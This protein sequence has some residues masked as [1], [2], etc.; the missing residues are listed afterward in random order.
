[1]ATEEDG[2]KKGCAKAQLGENCTLQAAAD[3]RTGNV[4][5]QDQGNRHGFFR[6]AA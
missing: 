5:G 3:P 6:P 4:A 2:G 1:M